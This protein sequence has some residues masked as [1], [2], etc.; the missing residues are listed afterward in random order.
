MAGA[1]RLLRAG[2]YGWQGGENFPTAETTGPAAGTSFQTVG[3]SGGQVASGTGWTFNG[4]SMQVTGSSITISG[5]IIPWGVAI[6]DGCTDVTLTDCVISPVVT[7]PNVVAVGLR[8]C[9]D[10][11]VQRCTI[12]PQ[13]LRLLA[14]VKYTGTTGDI[15]NPAVRACNISGGENGVQLSTGVVQD[16]YI[17]DPGF[18]TAD[19]TNG[20]NVFGGT[21]TMLI[22]HNTVLTSRAQTDAIAL[23]QDNSNGVGEANKTVD[24]NLMAGG[25]YS[26]YGGD[27]SQGATSSIVITNNR[28]S[29]MYFAS[30]GFFG[31]F[32]DFTPGGTG[33]VWTGNTWYDGPS[34]G[35]AVPS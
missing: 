15:T 17:H 34:A 1:P 21:D 32:A 26:L 3:S 4:S 11:T 18:L 20:I 25:G 24:H 5:F 33:N 19:H 12:Y 29:A 13:G 31:P 8:D 28:F 23:F 10:V 16:N 2:T 7:G 27:G 22:Q 30:G 6:Q 35:T 9:T 14:G